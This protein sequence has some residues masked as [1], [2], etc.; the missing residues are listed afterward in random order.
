MHSSIYH[1][2][3]DGSGD[4]RVT[5]KKLSLMQ[6]SDLA[7]RQAGICQHHI[8]CRRAEPAPKSVA[9]GNGNAHVVEPI[10]VRFRTAG[11]T[12]PEH[13]RPGVERRIARLAR[14]GNQTLGNVTGI[15]EF[16]SKQAQNR[17]IGGYGY[18]SRDVLLH[19]FMR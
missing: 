1:W 11:S 6:L 15:R 13:A 5:I 14:L 17:R 3:F 10:A 7:L 16:A 8:P 18:P 12:A 4:G 2:S 19:A 9:V